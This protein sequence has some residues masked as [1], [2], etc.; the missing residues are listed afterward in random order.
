MKKSY[1]SP[2]CR[3]YFVETQLPL[4]GSQF[5][6]GVDSQNIVFSEEETD[7]PTSRG[8]YEWD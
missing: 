7:S 1:I 4:A 6:T 8:F 3:L 5:S 2:S